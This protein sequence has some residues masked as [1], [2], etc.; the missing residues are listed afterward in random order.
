MTPDNV[1]IA[2]AERLQSDSALRLMALAELEFYLILDRAN[3]RFSG[4]AQRS[5][6]QSEPY[7][8]GR[9]VVDEMLRIIGKITGAVKYAHSEVGYI[10]KIES[11]DRELDGRRV[12]QHEI[13]FDLMPI[14]DLGCWLPVSRWLIRVIADRCGASVTF[15]PKLD[16]GMAGSGLHLHLAIEKQ[17]TNL[18]EQGDGGLSEPA[19]RLIGGLLERARSLS[20]FGNTVAA[21]YL[22]LVPGQEAPTRVCWGRRNRLSLIRVPLSFRTN[23]RVDLAMN[24]GEQSPA[25]ED[26]SRP[27]I[28]YRG[29]DGSAFTHLLLAAVT[30]CVAEGLVS[31]SA[32][33]TA[34]E[35]EVAADFAGDAA[36]LT[37]LPELP[38]TAVAAAEL[39]RRDRGFYEA[40]GIPARLIDIVIGKLEQ[41]ADAGL[42]ARL[43]G[44]PAAERL[45]KS[46]QLMHK[47]LHKH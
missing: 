13:E 37:A 18:V 41:E 6:Q 33:Q 19:L 27:T 45:A 44:L 1:L 29:P 16:E 42:S 30:A 47:D 43:R 24:P 4:R 35:L 40:G 22:R 15:L 3:D 23:A 46:R 10:D 21:S 39:L 8:H 34:R 5:Y 25:L 32:L 2:A 17:G 36:R 12:E 7:L 38:T 11:N 14:E 28:E 31:A 20:G 26:L 9:A